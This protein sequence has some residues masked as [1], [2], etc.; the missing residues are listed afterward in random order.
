VAVAPSVLSADFSRLDREVKAVE[1]AGAEFLHLDVMDGHFVPN[2]TFGPLVV[3]AIERVN[4]AMVLDA[5]LMI[6]RPELYAERFAEAG[7]DLITVHVEAPGDV[8]GALERIET[9]GRK[10]GLAVNPE[11][12]LGAAEPFLERIDL[13]LIMSVHPG[14]P[15]QGFMAEVIPK[16]ER[17]RQIRQSRGLDYLIQVD[18]GI[19]ADTAPLVR[20]AGVDV[21]VAGTAVFKTPDYR[22]AIATL[23]G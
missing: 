11:T 9:A 14:F 13:L 17:A 6:S 21:I 3:A 1:E 12:D 16:I 5:H 18:G 23:R 7:A 10:K 20:E 4:S 19:N 2:I 8:A 22:Q 15:G